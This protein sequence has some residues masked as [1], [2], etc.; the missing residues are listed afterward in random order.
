[1]VVLTFRC[2]GFVARS[3]IPA[4]SRDWLSVTEQFANAGFDS[5]IQDSTIT[6]SGF[7]DQ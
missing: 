1:M 3:G 6:D 7:E 4:F 5:A 2:S